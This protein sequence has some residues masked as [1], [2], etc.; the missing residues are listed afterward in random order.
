M[1]EMSIKIFSN[2]VKGIRNHMKRK[3]IFNFCANLQ[4][5]FFCLQETHSDK[6]SETEWKTDW[7]GQIFFSHGNTNSLGVA[8]LARTN[9]NI[10][11][12]ITD[13]HGRYIILKVKGAVIIL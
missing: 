3:K 5:Q 10:V 6:L 11:D 7:G 8:I 4:C 9:Q 12:V 13:T 2:N 1:K